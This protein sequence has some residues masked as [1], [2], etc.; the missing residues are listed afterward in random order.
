MNLLSA[1]GLMLASTSSSVGQ[2]SLD[3][4]SVVK[5]LEPAVL[6]SDPS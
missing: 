3:E 2:P 6:E 5:G 4:R 1:V